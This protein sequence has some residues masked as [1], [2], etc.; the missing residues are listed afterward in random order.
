MN[1]NQTD[2]KAHQPVLINSLIEKLPDIAGTWVDCT[3]GGGGYSE[4]L[5]RAGAKKIIAID[6]DPSVLNHAREFKVRF[7]SKLELIEAKFSSLAEIVAKFELKKISGVVFDVG[8][9][10]MQIDV[11]SRGFSFQKEG[12]LDMRM[13]QRGTTAADIVNNSTEEELADIIFYYGEDRFARIIARA[14]VRERN[15]KPIETTDHLSEVVNRVVRQ[16][17]FKIK[18]NFN[19]ATRTFQALRIAVNDEL[20]ELYSGLVA[21]EKVL[22]LGGVLA[23]VSFH[24][25]EDRLIKQ[26]IKTRSSDSSG[27]SRYLPDKTSPKPTFKQLFNKVVKPN[28]KEISQNPRARSAKLRVAIKISSNHEPNKLPKIRFPQVKFTTGLNS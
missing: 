17:N 25:L 11:A 19:P 9:S 20:E 7:G 18:A 8:V 14:I 16:K 15:K 26:F 1:I 5:L 6:T 10:S 23:V 12:P 27:Q 22:D 28:F 2:K 4:A 24:S 21:A 13:S 3:F